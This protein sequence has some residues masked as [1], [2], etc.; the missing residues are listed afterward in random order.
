MSNR[1]IT[2]RDFMRDSAAVAASAAAVAAGVGSAGGLAAA[3]ANAADEAKKKTPSYNPDM[4]YRRLGK[5]G[6]WVSAVCLGG[7]WKRIDKV[8]A[9]KGRIDGWSPPESSA[10]AAAFH[11]NRYDV[12]TRC[13]EAGI[14]L[15]D[16]CSGAEIMAYAR[17][18]KGRRDKMFMSFSWYEKESRFPQWRTAKKLLQGLDEALKESGQ[19]HA[20]LWRISALTKGSDHTAAEEEEMMQALATARKQGKARFTGLSSHDRPWLQ[21]M[22]EKYPDEMQAVLTPYTA[23]T[24][25]LPTDGLFAALQK[26]DVGML[27]IKPFASN[28]LFKGDSSPASP[29]AEAD[30]RRARLAIRCI[31]ANPAVTA[32]IPGLISIQQV[33]NMALAVKEGRKLSGAERAELGEALD[34]MWANL[35][36]DYEWLREFKA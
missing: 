27:G 5:T 24:T 2:R 14:N 21:K 1:R 8:I 22:I 12:V 15:V 30:A 11:K 6:V 4:E 26:Q 17:A 28:S 16:A 34:E 36:Q 35:P 32:P 29:Q 7:H 9:A 13:L 3:E 18:L 20:D 10:D 23:S 31:L 19:E 33:D 25:A